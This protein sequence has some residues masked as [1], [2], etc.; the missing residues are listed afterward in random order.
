MKYTVITGASSGIGYYSALA[1]AKRGKNLIL[2]ARREDKL[3]ELKEQV[4]EIS[5]QVDVQI[6]VYDLSVTENAHKFYEAVRDFDIETW[7]NNAGIGNWGIVGEQSIAKIEQMIRLNIE[8]LTILSSL[9]VR[10]Y[11]NVEGTQLIN[12]SSGGGYRILPNNIIY[13]ATKFFVSS[14]TEGLAHELVSQGAK[15]KAKVLAPAVTA[16][17]FLNTAMESDEFSYEKSVPK[18]HTAEEMA[19]FI[20]ELYEGNQVVGKVDATTYDFLLQDPIFPHAFHQ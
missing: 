2:V 10:D 18:Y 12:V 15:L 3:M 16:T 9:Y 6:F 17:E 1:F 13:C 20:I 4:K 19:Q 11:A 8:T 7:I 5:D 14:F